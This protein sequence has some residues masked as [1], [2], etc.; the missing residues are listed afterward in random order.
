MCVQ[1][2]RTVVVSVSSW[3][4]LWLCACPVGKDR[5]CVSSW[6]IS[7]L[8][9]CVQLERTVAVFVF[10]CVRELSSVLMSKCLFDE[11]VSVSVS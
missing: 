10:G 7:Q 8:C 5:G 2:E 9:V 6:K 3:K 11:L 4:G 1:L